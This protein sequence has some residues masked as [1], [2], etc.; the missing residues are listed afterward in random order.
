MNQHES[1]A[2][3]AGVVAAILRGDEDQVEVGADSLSGNPDFAIGAFGLISYLADQLGSTRTR[4]ASRCFNWLPSQ[5]PEAPQ[6][7]R[8]SNG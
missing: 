4:L 1:I 2:T 7:R 3:V 8:R 5:H 6:T